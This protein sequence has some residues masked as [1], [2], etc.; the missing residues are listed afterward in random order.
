M[1]LNAIISSCKNKSLKDQKLLYEYTYQELFHV[2]LR[3]TNCGHDAE[4]VFNLD[5]LKIFRHIIEDQ[6]E[7]KII[8]V[9]H[10]YYTPYSNRSI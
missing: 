6:S 3:Y 4:E 10:Q 7:I 9:L 1:E 5:M 8:W 2:S